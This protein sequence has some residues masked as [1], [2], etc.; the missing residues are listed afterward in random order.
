MNDMRFKNHLPNYFF[1]FTRD[2][3][4]FCLSCTMILVETPTRDWKNDG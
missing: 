4:P 1:Q 2:D 3:L